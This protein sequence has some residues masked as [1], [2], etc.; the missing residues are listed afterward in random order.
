MNQDCS[1]YVEIILKTENFSFMVGKKIYLQNLKFTG[2]DLHL[3]N[4]K[5]EEKPCYS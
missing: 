1:D 5:Y 3:D 2:L 4:S